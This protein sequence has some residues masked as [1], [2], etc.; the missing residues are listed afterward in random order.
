[1]LSLYPCI[2]RHINKVETVC[3][4]ILSCQTLAWIEHEMTWRRGDF[5]L[6]WCR[7]RRRRRQVLCL[8]KTELESL[9]GD[10]Y[11]LIAAYYN[12]EGRIV[13]T[14]KCNSCGENEDDKT[15]TS[16]NFPFPECSP[17]KIIHAQE[18]LL[19]ARAKR[20]RP[21]L[22]DKQLTSW[23]ALMITAYCD[24]YNAFETKPE[25]RDKKCLTSPE[26][27]KNKRMEVWC[28]VTK[29]KSKKSMHTLKIT[30]ALLKHS[31]HCTVQHSIL[32]GWEAKFNRWIHTPTFSMIRPP[33]YSVLLPIWISPHRQKRD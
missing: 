17:T 16:I 2:R 31:L 14:W 10:D 11:Q 8:N 19:K 27:S 4:G 21:G 25:C 26:E 24:V 5:I 33:D 6:L 22:N 32:C 28:I 12:V 29:R 20:I 23:N 3:T 18:I 30:P 7:F 15:I 1:M 9:L 13:G